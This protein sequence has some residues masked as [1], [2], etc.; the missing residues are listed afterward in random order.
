MHIAKP[1]VFDLFKP[2]NLRT[3]VPFLFSYYNLNM[4][5]FFLWRCGP[6]RAIASSFLRFL[7]HTQRLIT[8]S[9]TPLDVWSA[10]LINLYLTI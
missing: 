9:R 1:Y 2:Q 8:V 6:T 4:Y 10:R 5:I 7:D 3:S